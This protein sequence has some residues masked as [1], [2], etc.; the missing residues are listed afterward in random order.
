MA[1]IAMRDGGWRLGGSKAVWGGGVPVQC[2][3]TLALADA[4]AAEDMHFLRF[5]QLV[6]EVVLVT[7]DVWRA[8]SAKQLFYLCGRSR[9]EH[10]ARLLQL[11]W[12]AG[13]S[14]ACFSWRT[15]LQH[16]CAGMWLTGGP[17]WNKRTD[18]TLVCIDTSTT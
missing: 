6:R 14:P 9:R 1:A 12:S 18:G 11:G 8:E 2:E 17:S 16:P 3:D 10:E 7:V 4:V 13:M 15:L 5:R